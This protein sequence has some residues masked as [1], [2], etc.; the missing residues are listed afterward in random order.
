MTLTSPALLCI[1]LISL[2]LLCICH[3]ILSLF[4][5]FLEILIRIVVTWDSWSCYIESRIILHL[6]WLMKLI[7]A[8]LLGEIGSRENQGGVLGRA[9]PCGF[10]CHTRSCVLVIYVRTYYYM[11][12]HTCVQW[13]VSPCY[14]DPLTH[15]LFDMQLSC[16]MRHMRVALV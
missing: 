5:I 16:G 6:H 12:H 1:Y 7:K 14:Q 10:K 15:Q 3:S 11:L 2:T 4:F 8:G 13:T 9:T